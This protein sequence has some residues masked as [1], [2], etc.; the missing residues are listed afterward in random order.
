MKI[1]KVLNYLNL[2]AFLFLLSSCNESKNNQLIIGNWQGTEWL[3]NGKPSANNAK[4]TSFSFTDKGE[5]TFDYAGTIEKG[6]YKVENN[7]GMI[8][9]QGDNREKMK[10]ILEEKKMKYKGV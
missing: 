5:Y 8:E 9:V 4:G 7:F 1:K 6:T 10:K 3:V 2:L